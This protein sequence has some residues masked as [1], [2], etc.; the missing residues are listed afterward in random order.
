M[1]REIYRGDDY[2]DDRPVL[3]Y[4]LVSPE[5]DPITEEPY[6]MDLRGCTVWTTFKIAPTDIELDPND[7][8]AP[9]KAKIE[10]N[11]TGQPVVEERFSLPPDGTAEEGILYLVLDR[12]ETAPLVTDE[13]L[14]CD[15]Q[16]MDINGRVKTLPMLATVKAIDGYTNR[17]T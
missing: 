11:A 9:I 2:L 3:V 12:T 14:R 15:V 17:T 4:E 1:D 7:M 5:I 16:V 8:D 10:F 13:V 6:P